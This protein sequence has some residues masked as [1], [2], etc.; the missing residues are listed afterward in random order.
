M[1][2]SEDKNGR[3]KRKN[4]QRVMILAGSVLSVA[5]VALMVIGII[6]FR[7]QSA[8]N[9]ELYTNAGTTLSSRATV[10]D[11]ATVSVR[12]YD[13]ATMKVYYV[14]K[15]TAYTDLSGLDLSSMGTEYTAGSSI[16]LTRS[17]TTEGTRYLYIQ[18]KGVD[19]PLP[20]ESYKISFYKNLVHA[21]STPSTSASNM[22]SIKV[23]DEI[24]FSSLGTMYYTDD[25]SEPG[26]VRSQR[27][28]RDQ[29]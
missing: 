3:K 25:D 29:R 23:G 6:S 14:L 5:A 17:S 19:G 1:L 24:I 22:A 8:D 28:D 11:G 7:A 2:V 15:D 18:Q 13:S 27:Y 9:L 16:T 4:Y 12:G 21:T 20:I 26:F 10:M